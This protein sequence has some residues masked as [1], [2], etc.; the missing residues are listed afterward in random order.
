MTDKDINE[1]LEKVPLIQNYELMR[2]MFMY[3]QEDSI[4]CNFKN[5]KDFLWKLMK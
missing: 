1:K 2:N 3:H 5:Y 4:K